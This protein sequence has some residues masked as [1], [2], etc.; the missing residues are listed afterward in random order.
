MG[1]F[2]AI[3]VT[4]EGEVGWFGGRGSQNL[5]QKYICIKIRFRPTQLKSR[6]WPR[7][8][9]VPVAGWEGDVEEIRVQVVIRDINQGLKPF[10]SLNLIRYI[11]HI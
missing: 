8:Y 10:F 2:P 4:L 9:K 5:R 7:V 11:T 3:P 1:L 6:V